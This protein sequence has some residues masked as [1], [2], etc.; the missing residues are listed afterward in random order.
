MIKSV[1]HININV[2]DFDRSLAFYQ[3]LGFKEVPLYAHLEE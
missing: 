3:N 2:K 1:F